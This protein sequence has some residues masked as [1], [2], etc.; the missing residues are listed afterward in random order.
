MEL[1]RLKSELYSKVE[2]IKGSVKGGSAADEAA[3]MKEINQIMAIASE[4]ESYSAS[5][6]NIQQNDWE[7][8]SEK[9]LLKIAEAQQML[10][11]N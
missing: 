11:R 7:G 9:V 5:L 8:F 1:Y 6:G 3:V 4:L 10:N 2:T